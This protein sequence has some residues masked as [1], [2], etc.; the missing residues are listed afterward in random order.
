MDFAFAPGKGAC[1]Y[2]DSVLQIP[3]P[4]V[5]LKVCQR[6]E[7]VFGMYPWDNEYIPADADRICIGQ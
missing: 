1:S 5:V 7:G 6:G 3:N 4:P 2:K